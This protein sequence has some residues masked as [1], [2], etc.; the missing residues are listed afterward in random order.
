MV[1]SHRRNASLGHGDTND[2][3][4]PEQVVLERQDVSE[5]TEHASDTIAFKLQPAL[6][7]DVQMSRLHSG[8]RGSFP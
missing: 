5:G 3:I 4:H 7:N 8:M 6:V 2:R 1:L